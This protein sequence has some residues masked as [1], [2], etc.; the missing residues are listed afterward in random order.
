M[1]A[2]PAAESDFGDDDTVD[3]AVAEFVMRLTMRVALRGELIR[4]ALRQDVEAALA[5]MKE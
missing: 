2:L 1:S 5:D 4:A 3:G